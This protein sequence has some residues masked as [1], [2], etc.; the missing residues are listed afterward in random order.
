MISPQLASNQNGMGLERSSLKIIAT[1]ILLVSK[2]I[3]VT[4]T[5]I[6]NDAF[7][8]PGGNCKAWKK[9]L[10]TGELWWREQVKYFKVRNCLIQTHTEWML[11]LFIRLLI[12]HSCF[13][14][15]HN[16]SDQ[17]NTRC[18]KDDGGTSKSDILWPQNKAGSS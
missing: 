13:F 3:T 18:F 7:L 17:N 11:K 12:N 16:I 15:D 6:K 9:L 2:W 5:V 1:F 4:N 10:V 14:R 8:S